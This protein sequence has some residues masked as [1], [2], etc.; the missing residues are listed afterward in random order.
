MLPVAQLLEQLQLMAPES[1]VEVWYPVAAGG[2][3]VLPLR[4]GE[5]GP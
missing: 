1:A 3:D 4:A 5:K 2:S